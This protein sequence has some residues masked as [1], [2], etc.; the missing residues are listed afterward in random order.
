ML[1]RRVIQPAVLLLAV[2]CADPVSPLSR[3]SV[4]GVYI[5]ETVTGQYAPNKGSL[6]L[7]SNGRAR[8]S[9]SYPAQNG[10]GGETVV[11]SGTFR[12]P[13]E[14]RIDLFLIDDCPSCA[15][16]G[17]RSEGRVTFY[18]PGPADGEIVETYRRVMP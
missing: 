15:F 2:S 11:R 13:T 6:V 16:V 14:T 8:R 10:F 17:T 4:A 5:L 9:I 18:Y 12:L 1:F 7:S 3:A